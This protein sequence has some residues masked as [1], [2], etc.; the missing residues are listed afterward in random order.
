MSDELA[1]LTEEEKKALGDSLDDLVRET[2]KTPVAI[3][4]FKRLVAKAGTGA[5]EGFKTLLLDIVSEAVR[6]QIWGP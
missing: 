5:A 6:K 3:T 4:R 2:P 1:G